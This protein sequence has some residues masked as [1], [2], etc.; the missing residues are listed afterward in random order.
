MMRNIKFAA[1]AALFIISESASAAPRQPLNDRRYVT[2][3]PARNSEECETTTYTIITPKPGAKPTPVTKQFQPV[4][5]CTPEYVVCDS[6]NKEKCETIYKTSS[7]LWVSTEV[8]CYSG[9]ATVTRVNQPITIAAYPTHKTETCHCEKAGTCY[10]GVTSTVVAQPTQFPYVNTGWEYK[11]CNYND[12]YKWYNGEYSP[13]FSGMK[14]LGGNDGYEPSPQKPGSQGPRP[15]L[16]G[17]KV[18]YTPVYTS[19]RYG[20]QGPKY[21]SGQGGYSHPVSNSKS[22]YHGEYKSEYGGNSKPAYHGAYKLGYK[23]NGKPDY[24]G[25]SKLGFHGSYKPMYNGE[26]KSVNHR[27]D[28]PAYHSE[29]PGYQGEYKPS[30]NSEYKSGYHGE[31]KPSYHGEPQHGYQGQYKPGYH[32]GNKPTYYGEHKPG[33]HGEN[34]PVYHGE[35]KPEYHGERKPAYHGKYK[36][37]YQGNGSHKMGHYAG[38]KGYEGSRG[39]PEYYGKTD[40]YKEHSGNKDYYSKDR[41]YKGSYSKGKGHKGNYGHG[42]KDIPDGS[43][44]GAGSGGSSTTTTSTSSSGSGNASIEPTF[45]GTTSTGTLSTV[46]GNAST[47]S[48]SIGP[49][50][51]EPP[52]TT[53]SEP[54]GRGG[55]SIGGEP[56]S[57][58]P[59]STVTCSIGPDHVETCSTRPD[60]TQ[61]SGPNP[62]VTCSIGP[63]AVETC[64][65][66]PDSTITF[67]PG[68]IPTETCSIGPDS[69]E[70]CSTVPNPIET[71][72]TGPDS[73]ETC[74]IRPNPTETCSIGLDSIETCSTGPESWETYTTPFSST[75]PSTAAP[76]TYEP[77]ETATE[78]PSNNQEPP[79]LYEIVE[80]LNAEG[81]YMNIGD[82]GPC[83]IKSLT[84]A[85]ALQE[86]KRSGGKI[87]TNLIGC[88]TDTG[89]ADIDCIL[90]CNKDLDSL[91]LAQRCLKKSGTIEDPTI[92]CAQMGMSG[93][94]QL[95]YKA[96]VASQGGKPCSRQFLKRQTIEDATAYA[97][98]C[99]AAGLLSGTV[100][101]CVETARL[102]LDT[103]SGVRAIHGVKNIVGYS[104]TERHDSLGDV[105][106]NIHRCFSDLLAGS[107]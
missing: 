54:S 10:Y 66:G 55:T 19:Q 98:E 69:I 102:G 85:K 67:P 64:S 12:Y 23:G 16:G 13:E 31:Y 76:T 78:L 9:I 41:G 95:L 5:S 81:T 22:E 40:T 32:G 70:T 99:A 94:S 82:F 34:K 56:T 57:T 84:T 11:V 72:S 44:V 106:S 60:S 6:K 105:G 24:H 104:G 86:C 74:S 4:Y 30:H 68:P 63:D 97:T 92:R 59:D 37:D 21:N 83:A 3:A 33:Y 75:V 79:Q 65:N 58:G 1:L 61:T 88:I 62:T 36:P 28:K 47:G 71:C 48:T 7:Y 35:Y 77:S 26:Y 14:T 38:G 50:S 42:G 15:Y 18:D 46:G 52:A 29:K 80:G 53:S 27:K 51:T 100:K 87:P 20:N 90:S 25:E 49:S 101:K 96:C 91:T 2:A 43:V 17:G 39:V 107:F 93:G 73:V 89:I 8:P 103:G 45:T